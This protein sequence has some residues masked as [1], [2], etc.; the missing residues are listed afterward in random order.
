MKSLDMAVRRGVTLAWA[1]G[2]ITCFN[3]IDC[4]A[5]DFTGSLGTPESDGDPRSHP[6]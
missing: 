1:G 3:V 4:I 5:D 2:G 6:I